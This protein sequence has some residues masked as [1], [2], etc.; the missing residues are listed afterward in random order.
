M[1]ITHCVTNFKGPKKENDLLDELDFLQGIILLSSTWIPGK[2]SKD[3]SGH[4]ET[5]FSGLLVLT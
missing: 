5:P 3:M 2:K 4:K 1:C